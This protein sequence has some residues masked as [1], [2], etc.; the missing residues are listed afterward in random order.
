MSEENNI[1][2]NK[3]QYNINSKETSIRNSLK[4]SKKRYQNMRLFFTLFI[5]FFCRIAC[6]VIIIFISIKIKNESDKG[7]GNVGLN[8]LYERV[9]VDDPN[10]IYIPIISTNNIQGNF[11]PKETV[12]NNITYAS[13]GL[14]YLLRYINILKDEFGKKRIIYLDAGNLY[15]AS[16][17]TESNY[18]TIFFNYI[19]V[20]KAFLMENHIKFEDIDDKLNKINS[21]IYENNTENYKI[22]K[23]KFINGDIIKIGII[24]FL[25]NGKSQLQEIKNEIILNINKLKEEGANAI[26]LLTNLETR[27]V[28]KSL[29]LNMFINTKQVCDEYSR[30]NKTIFNVLKN[31]SSIDAV[32]VPNSYDL[33]IHH[34]VNGIPIMSSPSKGKYFNIMYLPFKKQFGKYILYNEGIK[35][36]GPIP[37][38]G[39]IFNDTKICDNEILSETGELIDFF[40]HG[41]KIFKDA[42]LK[43]IENNVYNLSFI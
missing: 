20:N 37:I 11:Y 26:I 12:E 21:T 14:I 27:C 39:K 35:I 4:E 42:S 36:E 43:I 9:K 17:I 32:I 2:Y 33:E 5:F 7:N 8:S 40:W 25:I 1:S 41:R 38:C 16:N 28:G 6:I 23:M 3:N 31:I 29:K 19:D 34:W 24:S 30:N 13:G 10:Y 18:T 22:F 15:D